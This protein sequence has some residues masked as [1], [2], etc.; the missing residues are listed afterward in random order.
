MSEIKL[1]QC[2]FC[3]GDTY[4]ATDDGVKFRTVCCDCGITTKLYYD[5]KRA[6]E[7]WN[8]RVD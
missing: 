8:R 1:K 3:G 5:V 6:A 4:F 7:I 2:P